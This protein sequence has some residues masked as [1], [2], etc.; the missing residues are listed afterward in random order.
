MAWAMLGQ[1]SV[2]ANPTRHHRNVGN[3]IGLSMALHSNGN[4]LALSDSSDDFSSKHQHHHL[5]HHSPLNSLPP[6]TQPTPTLESQPTGLYLQLTE[7]HIASA[8][9]ARLC[10]GLDDIFI[11]LFLILLIL[12]TVFGNILVVLSV[13]LY[14]RMR[15]FTNILLTSLA[16]ADLLI[17]MPLALV[18][19]LYSHHWPFGRLLCSIWAT[20]DVFL[21]TCS[22]LNLCII[23]LDRYMAITS[24]LKYPRTRSRLMAFV[25]LGSVWFISLIGIFD[26]LFNT[27]QSSFS[28]FASLVC[29]WMG[30]VHANKIQKL[31][32]MTLSVF[33]R[34][35]FHTEYV[36]C[37]SASG[38]FY[39]PLTVML[40]VYY[41]IFKVASERE[42]LMRQT[43]GTCRLSR[44]IDK[45]RRRQNLLQ[46][47]YHNRCASAP[48]A[49]AREMQVLNTNDTPPAKHNNSLY[50]SEGTEQSANDKRPSSLMTSELNEEKEN[51]DMDSPVHLVINNNSNHQNDNSN[52]LSAVES[53]SLGE[54]G[55]Q[56]QKGLIN[57]IHYFYSYFL[58]LKEMPKRKMTE[59]TELSDSVRRPS[60]VT[61][62]EKLQPTHLVA[63]A[64]QHYHKHGPGKA[65]RGSKEKIVYLRERKALKTIGIVVLGFIICWLPFFVLYLVEVFITQLSNA[66]SFRLLSE[67]FLWLGYSNS[68][69][70]PIIYTLYNGDFRRCFRD[71]LGFGCVQ[72]HRRTMSV[73]KLHQSTVF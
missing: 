69:I 68:C 10:L 22:I 12:L 67:F 23:S 4:L 8:I 24:P 30:L 55:Q 9:N 21:C 34:H 58:N 2:G 5:A 43:L 20:T 70:N 62:N 46:C 49:R 48:T 39:I 56:R 1:F 50:Y 60:I 18:D 40:F 54:F 66:Y 27:L 13:F 45:T 19:L 7:Q 33:I 59:T 15:T 6:T 51:S 16:T 29:A 71:L 38:S 17:V 61:Q 44:R 63:K 72:H 3:N 28:L 73:K 25:L 52:N 26:L 64:Q 37:N 57:P 11:A 42:K 31:Q 65:I 32:R 41:R 47:N 53:K 35:Q 36:S 14:K